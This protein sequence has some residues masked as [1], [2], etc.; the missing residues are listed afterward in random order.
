MKFIRKI[1]SK[2]FILF[3]FI[4]EKRNSNRLKRNKFLWSELES[5]LKKTKSTGCNISDYWELY[6]H[7]RKYKPKE[8]LEC[9]TGVST[10]VI[11]T[12]LIEN[13]KEGFSG[14]ITSM[15]SINKYLKMAKDILPTHF[16][17]YVDFVL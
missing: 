9:G 15:E 3:R 11:A 17:K 4:I 10:I 5:Y 12:A 14:R 13:E 8:V 16:V 6:N 1:K 7:V 2:V